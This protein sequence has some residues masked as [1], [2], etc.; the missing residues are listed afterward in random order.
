MQGGSLSPHHPRHCHAA[1]PG[2]Q[3]GGGKTGWPCPPHLSPELQTGECGGQPIADPMAL[4]PETFWGERR[5]GGSSPFPT[6]VH[7]GG[8]GT[9]GVTA[10]A[11]GQAVEEMMCGSLEAP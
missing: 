9:S 3:D 11:P 4:Q 10:V 7:Q 2:V 5:D 1:L 8:P 6:V